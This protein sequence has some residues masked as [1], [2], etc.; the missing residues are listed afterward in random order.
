MQ[1]IKSIYISEPIH[2]QETLSKLRGE[3]HIMHKGP[4]M[5][6]CTSIEALTTLY[7]SAIYHQKDVDAIGFH[8]VRSPWHDF[9]I[10]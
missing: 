8:Y 9:V 2:Y 5:D 7:S 1:N 10:R 3:Y 4:Q 6:T